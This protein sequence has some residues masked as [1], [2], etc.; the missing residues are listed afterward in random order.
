MWVYNN[1][2]RFPFVK[3]QGVVG[4]IFLDAGNVFTR[5]DEFRLIGWR[6]VG[7]GIR[8]YSAVGPL[9]FEYGRKLD[10]TPDESRG[11]YEFSIGGL[12]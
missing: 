12:F 2:Y 10:R 1:E 11:E 7:C 9:R 3:D 6:S 4:L 5:E 8:W